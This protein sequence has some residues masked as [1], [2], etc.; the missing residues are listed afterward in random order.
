MLQEEKLTPD[1]LEALAAAGVIGFKAYLGYAFSLSRKQVLYSPEDADSDLESPPDYGTL[2]RVAPVIAEL[3]L[4][5][6]IHAEDPTVL[7]AF[8][9]PLETYSDLLEARPAEAEAVAIS[10]AAAIATARKVLPVPAGPMP[11]T[12]SFC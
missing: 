3:G 6:A 8:R 4:P 7:S 9:R 11:N 1:Q 12:M 2:A 10:A 5:L